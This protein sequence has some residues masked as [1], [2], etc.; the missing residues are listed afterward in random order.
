MHVRTIALRAL[1]VIAAMLASPAIAATPSLKEVREAGVIIQRWDTSCGAAAIATVLTYHFD[2]PASEGEV[3]KGMLGMTDPLTVRYR[4][5]F[6]LLDMKRYAYERG[7]RAFGFRGMM[8]DQIRFFN[9]AIVP[10]KL[11]GYNHYVV[12]KGLTP[13]GRV[14]IADPAY[15][16]RTLGRNR[17]ERAWIDGLAFVLLRNAA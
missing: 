2:D 13:S 14:A 17:F 12:V 9:G 4:G 3:A 11:H 6:S 15:G 5:G 8:L 1:L 10:L 16:N 7:Y